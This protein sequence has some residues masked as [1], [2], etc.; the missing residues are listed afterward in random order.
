MSSASCF[1]RSFSALRSPSWP[2]PQLLHRFF[3]SGLNQPTYQLAA[4]A[5]TFLSCFG[6]W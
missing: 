4:S 6:S 3:P 1:S 2:G 5:P